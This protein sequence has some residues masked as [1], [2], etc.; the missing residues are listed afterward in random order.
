MGL[1]A[2]LQWENPS[3][4]SNT[5]LADD[6]VTTGKIA[7]GAVAASDLASDAV[8]TVKILNANVTA[9][10]LATDNASVTLVDHADT[11]PVSLL[12][13]A[14]GVTRLVRVTA[15]CEET[16]GGTTP[17]TM[18]VGTAGSV[19][20][21]LSAAALAPTTGGGDNGDV[22]EGR[23]ILPA[24]SALICTVTAGSGGTPAGKIRFYVTATPMPT[25]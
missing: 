24:A 19:E 15:V 6:S 9:A 17:A 21:A 10:K 1:N 2:N 11:S 13:A 22:T 18:S 3:D 12:A 8:T 20:L 14:T 23:C 5:E 4:V 16:L 25:P 7:S